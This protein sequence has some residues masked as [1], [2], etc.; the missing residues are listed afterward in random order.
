MIYNIYVELS[1]YEQY[2]VGWCIFCG[3]DCL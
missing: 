2:S 3:A 1:Y